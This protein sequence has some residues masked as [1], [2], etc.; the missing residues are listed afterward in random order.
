MLHNLFKIE[1]KNISFS[2][3]ERCELHQLK[4]LFHIRKQK[5]KFKI[6]SFQL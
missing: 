1:V 2:I 6:I 3:R 5:L 4:I